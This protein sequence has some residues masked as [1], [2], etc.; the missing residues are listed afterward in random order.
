MGP[1]QAPDRLPV[2][3]LGRVIVTGASGLLGSHLVARLSAAGVPA[4]T[5]DVRSDDRTIDIQASVLD[6]DSAMFDGSAYD[7]LFHFAGIVG[8]ERVW[9]DVTQTVAVNA[10]GTGRAL[11]VARDLGVK[12]FVIAST[13]AVYGEPQRVP[14]PED[15]PLR[16]K[17]PYAWAKVCAEQLLEATVSC[18]GHTGVVLRPFNVYGPGQ[19][20]QHVVP[21]F[22]DQALSGTALT[23]VGD[24]Q[25]TRS[26]L[27]V[28]D[29]VLA[30]LHAAIYA[31]TGRLSV[32]NIAHPEQVT[33]LDLAHRILRL[34][35]SH[36]EVTF[37]KGADLGR[38]RR[39]EVQHRAADTSQAE[40]QLHFRPEF[41]LEGGLIPTINSR[42]TLVGGKAAP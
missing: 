38:H 20:A 40:R 35:G 37:V 15:A 10:A 28:E 27:Y 33:L 24:G 17:S 6:L 22:I 25:Q 1:H 29:F 12:R 8:V 11:R 14:T 36:S 41:S 31:P 16:A 32:F 4:T 18:G 23:L 30:A 26:F 3:A 19:S 2:K 7:T 9:Q 5:V 13:S 21:R 42:R 39:S 34:T